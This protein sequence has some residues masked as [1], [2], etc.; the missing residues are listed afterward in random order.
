LWSWSI[1]AYYVYCIISIVDA[2]ALSEQWNRTTK[3]CMHLAFLYN[4][5]TS[6]S[7]WV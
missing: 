3:K 5:T 2:A 7:K 6:L 1:L 4:C